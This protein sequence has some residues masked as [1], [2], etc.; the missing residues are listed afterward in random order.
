MKE[1][2]KAY[3]RITKTSERLLEN[4]HEDRA[5]HGDATTHKSAGQQITK[6]HQVVHKEPR[7]GRG[8]DEKGEA[9]TPG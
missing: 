6:R 4:G 2:R 9:G 7:L 5:S 8:T 1:T 3:L